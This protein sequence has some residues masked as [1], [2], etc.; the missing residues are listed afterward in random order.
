MSMKTMTVIFS[1][2]KEEKMTVINIE[3][4]IFLK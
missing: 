1:Q 4:N 3:S 2:K